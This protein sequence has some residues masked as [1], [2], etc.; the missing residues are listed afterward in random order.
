MCSSLQHAM[1]N[2]K[3]IINETEHKAWLPSG[4]QVRN[5]GVLNSFVNCKILLL[6]TVLLWVKIRKQE[7]VVLCTRGKLCL[8]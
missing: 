5:F 3:V 8:N 2:L 7:S 6:C 1:I 4:S